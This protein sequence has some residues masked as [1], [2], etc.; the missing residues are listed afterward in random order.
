MITENLNK[1]A[2]EMIG[3]LNV[4][5]HCK[6]ANL[7]ECLQNVTTLEKFFSNTEMSEWALFTALYQS[8]SLEFLF[9]I[10]IWA[11]ERNKVTKYKL[12]Y[13]LTLFSFYFVLQI[14][15]YDTIH[16]KLSHSHTLLINRRSERGSWDIRWKIYPNTFA[17]LSFNVRSKKLC[18]FC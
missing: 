9:Y 8:W 6:T 1:N 2:H 3:C 18:S 10:C 13:I 11:S 4:E 17:H 15:L 12:K 16:S 7:S 5:R 14:K